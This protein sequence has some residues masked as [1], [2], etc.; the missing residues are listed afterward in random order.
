MEPKLFVLIKNF[1]L[2]AQ[3][4]VNG[5][6]RWFRLRKAGEEECS[7]P[8][9]LKTKRWTAFCAC[10]GSGIYNGAFGPMRLRLRGRKKGRSTDQLQPYKELFVSGREITS[11]EH[12]ALLSTLLD[13]ADDVVMALTDKPID[14]SELGKMIKTSNDYNIE[15]ELQ[16][17]TPMFSGNNQ[18]VRLARGIGRITGVRRL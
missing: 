10:D 1:C 13:N 8:Y 14:A 12:R 4:L 17:Q 6:F 2:G 15:I 9:E 16:T 3:D 7:V 11:A 18:S 5:Q